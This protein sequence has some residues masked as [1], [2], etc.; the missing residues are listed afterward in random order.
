LLDE[1][2]QGHGSGEIEEGKC[3]RNAPLPYCPSDL[4]GQMNHLIFGD[5][6]T[7]DSDPF[8]EGHQMRGRIETNAIPTPTQDRMDHSRSGSLAVG[9]SDMD[10]PHLFVGISEGLQNIPNIVQAKNDPVVLEAV[11]IIQRVPVLP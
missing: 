2:E 9:A 8:G 3:L 11:E 5:L 10:G 1:I 4:L 7:I 6:S